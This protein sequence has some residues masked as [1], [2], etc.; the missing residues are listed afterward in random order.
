M[1]QQFFILLLILVVLN[2]SCSQA[3]SV[4]ANSNLTS[5]NASSSEMVSSNSAIDNAVD[6]SAGRQ[7]EVINVE[8]HRNQLKLQALEVGKLVKSGDFERLADYTHPK[9]FE[10][11]GGRE[12]LIKNG[13]EAV[14]ELKK[15]GFEIVSTKVGEPKDAVAVGEELFSNVP[16]TVMLKTPKGTIQQE[17]TLVAVSNDNG[18]NW[19]FLSDMNQERFKAL[20]PI[21]ATRLQIPEDKDVPV[22]QKKSR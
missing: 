11:A 16:M 21:A 2:I 3:D 20:F 18:A 13:R 5:A 8:A 1:R 14:E 9:V 6:A 22:T 17:T 10:M 12:A 19:K 4:A 15:E 7:A